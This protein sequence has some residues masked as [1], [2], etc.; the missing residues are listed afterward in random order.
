MIE[1]LTCERIW[2]Y[3]ECLAFCWN[4]ITLRKY[5]KLKTG[6]ISKATSVSFFCLL[7]WAL[8]TTPVLWLLSWLPVLSDCFLPAWTPKS[9]ISLVSCTH[10]KHRAGK[11]V[12]FKWCLIPYGLKT[13]F[14]MLEL[15]SPSTSDI[16]FNPGK[17]LL[18]L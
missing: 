15:P 10:Y 3:S 2:K 17:C 13:I 14:S 7:V 6:S 4:S 16:V 18:L 8:W 12:S 1:N 11:L 5:L 9:L